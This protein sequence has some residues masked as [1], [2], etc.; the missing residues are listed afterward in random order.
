MFLDFAQKK[1][2]V[3]FFAFFFLFF[4]SHQNC[5]S[6][7]SYLIRN[8]GAKYTEELNKKNT[9]LI[10]LTPEGRK[11]DQAVE[12]KIPVIT[13]DWIFDCAKNWRLLETDAY[14][15]QRVTNANSSPL[16]KDIQA[17]SSSPKAADQ[18]E[19]QLESRENEGI[20]DNNHEEET[21]QQQQQQE[22]GQSQK[23]S[24]NQEKLEEHEEEIHESQ[25]KLRP[26]QLELTV[27]KEMM[28]KELAAKQ[29]SMNFDEL[30]EKAQ[31]GE[32]IQQEQLALP[33]EKPST[34]EMQKDFE[35]DGER[36]TSS[37]RDRAEIVKLY[38]NEMSFVEEKFRNEIEHAHNQ[39]FGTITSGP[40]AGGGGGG[41]GGG[42]VGSGNAEIIR[43]LYEKTLGTIQSLF[44]I[45]ISALEGGGASSNATA[46]ALD[47]QQQQQMIQQNQEE[48]PL[49]HEQ[50]NNH[51]E[52]EQE[53][54]IHEN[55]PISP[56]QQQ[57]QPQPHQQQ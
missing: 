7:L 46:F 33:E 4:Q 10:C 19:Q 39:S 34:Q 25:K 23:R 24:R 57:P 2:L 27:E 43:S 35:I 38:N 16:S 49:N 6:D 53:R 31:L 44:S 13:K 51:Q 8:I 41:G 48:N 29:K 9:H 54:E 20:T 11:F 37:K 15:I 1:D 56:E 52:E 22:E 28:M 47:S 30:D 32:E 18:E 55:A 36:E 3:R 12:W 5:Q 14:A 45:T 50:E 42:A 26:S 21:D 40:S 17:D